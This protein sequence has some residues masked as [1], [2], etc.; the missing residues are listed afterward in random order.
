MLSLNELYSPQMA[1]NFVGVISFLFVL[2]LLPGRVLAQT[3]G[4]HAFEFQLGSSNSVKPFATGYRSGTFGLFHTALSY[5][6]MFNEYVGMRPTL[7]YDRISNA[8]DGS[9]L[10]FTSN[11]TRFTIQGAVNTGQ[12]LRFRE[13]TRNF[14]VFIYGGPGLSILTSKNA[15]L[16]GLMMNAT[17]SLVPTFKLSDNLRLFLDITR[18][19]H[20]YQQVTFDLTSRYEELGYDG[21]IYNISFGVSFNP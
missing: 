11:Y 4:A 2:T 13:F 7:A 14:T 20:V 18:V 8:K 9:S 5:K 6:L 21:L 16:S 17:A 10:P 3:P 12:L 15:N 19:R 1:R